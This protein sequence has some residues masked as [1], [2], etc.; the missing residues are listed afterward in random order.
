M[1]HCMGS[2]HNP[3]IWARGKIYGRQHGR[4]CSPWILPQRSKSESLRWLRLATCCQR[5]KKR[6]SGTWAMHQNNA[7]AYMSG[8][9]SKSQNSCD[10]AIT[11]H[12]W[13]GSVL[14]PAALQLKTA[15]KGKRFKGTDMTKENMTKHLRSNKLFKKCFQ[16]WLH[17]WHK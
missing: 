9:S 2:P 15:L 14:L 13:H 12:L 11:L 4:D 6:V 3:K 10:S 5:P 16:Q 7:P 17:G 8:F 1:T